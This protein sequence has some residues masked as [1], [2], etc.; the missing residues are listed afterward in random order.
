MSGWQAPIRKRDF[1]STRRRFGRGVYELVF[2]P[3]GLAEWM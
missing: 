2:E 3:L 1:L